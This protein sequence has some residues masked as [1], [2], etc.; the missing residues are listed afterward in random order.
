MSALII[1]IQHWTGGPRQCRKARGQRVYQ[2]EKKV[3][4]SFFTDHS[5]GYAENP[6]ESTKKLPEVVS[7]ARL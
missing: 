4:V 5:I 7:L 1:P 6:N 3:K 2:L